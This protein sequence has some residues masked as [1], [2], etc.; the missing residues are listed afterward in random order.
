VGTNIAFLF[1]HRGAL[2]GV[3]DVAI[4]YLTQTPPGLLLGALSP[5]TLSF[6]RTTFAADA[7]CSDDRAACCRGAMWL[8]PA[9]PRRRTGS[10]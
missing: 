3:S 5:W 4:K 10:D 2:F 8:T 7:P 9:A 1:K 6:V